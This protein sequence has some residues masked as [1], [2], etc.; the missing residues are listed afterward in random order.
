MLA[1]AVESASR[2]L[3][4][5]T[6][7]R[8]E[9]L[10]REVAERKLDDG[11]FDE[12]G[13]TLRELR[14]IEKTHDQVA[15]RHLPRPRQVPRARSRCDPSSRSPTVRP[16][17]PSTGREAPPRRAHGLQGEEASTR[18]KS[19]WP[20]WT[21]R[22]SA[23][24]TADTSARTSRPTCS[25]SSWSAAEAGSKGRSSSAP[26]RPAVRPGSTAGPRPTN[27]CFT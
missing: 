16:R 5:P 25:A 20:S 11:Q 9:S 17:W 4:D 8:I 6:P 14:T 27:C 18:P 12:S 22:R 23:R 7:A 24:C 3:V 19:A 21:T 26:R 2:T 10:V 15:D 1:D 13:L